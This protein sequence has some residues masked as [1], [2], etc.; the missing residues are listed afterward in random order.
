MSRRKD[1]S[2]IYKITSPS[3]KV[4]IGRSY[5]IK[6]RW[7]T[8]RRMDCKDQNKLFASFFKYGVDNHEFMILH[9]LPNDVEKEVIERY[10]IIYLDLY[11]DCGVELLNLAPGGKGVGKLKDYQRMKA[12]SV[13]KGRS[14]WTKGRFG[15]DHNRSLQIVCNG[16]TYGSISEASR[17]TGVAISTIHYCVSKG[18]PLR[19]GMHFQL[20]KI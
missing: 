9:E 2:G 12:G 5:G 16:I 18:T 14:T 8:Y 4:Y 10:E 17:E 19:S 6:Q 20:S 7:R 11:K 13:H 3:G 15:K 1:I